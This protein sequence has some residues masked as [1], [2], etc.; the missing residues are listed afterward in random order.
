MCAWREQELGRKVPL[1]AELLAMLATE[2]RPHYVQVLTTLLRSSVEGVCDCCN[3]PFGYNNT[4]EMLHA[5]STLGP[6]PVRAQGPPR[7]TKLCLA[8]ACRRGRVLPLCL[9]HSAPELEIMHCC[10]TREVQGSAAG[11]P[12][13]SSTRQTPS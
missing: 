11:A 10:Q 3:V 2:A 5:R 7:H 4:T 9:W 8:G 6:L 12:W 13:Q 1:P